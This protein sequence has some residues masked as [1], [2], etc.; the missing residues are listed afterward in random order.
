[1]AGMRV[2]DHAIVAPRHSTD[3]ESHWQILRTAA[4]VGASLW[5]LVIAVAV[6]SAIGVDY[7][8]HFCGL[9]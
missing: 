8:L 1:M 5:L 3:D 4:V 7:V 6:G 9:E 2:Y